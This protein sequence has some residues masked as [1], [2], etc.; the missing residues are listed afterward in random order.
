MKKI[1]VQLSLALS[2]SLFAQSYTISQ[3][4]LPK[5][6][7]FNLSPYECNEDCLE[8][9][10]QKGMV[11]SFLAN[12]NDTNV[13]REKLLEMKNIY[14]SIFNLGASTIAKQI[15]IAMLIPY[16]KIGKYAT[17]T[18]NAVFAYLMTKNYSFELKSFSIE[19]ESY[20]DIQQAFEEIEEEGFKYVIAPLTYQ[21]L[22]QLFALGVE[23]NIYIPTINK[24]DLEDIPENFYF[25]GI[26]Y[27][28]Q[29]KVLLQH[30]AS[31]LVIFYDTSYTGEKLR[32]IQKS[33]FLD[34]VEDNTDL[35]T[36]N[37]EQEDDKKVFIFPVSSHNSNLKNI[38]KDNDDL[39]NSS[40]VLDTP[41]V[42]SGLIMS[43]L[44]LY[45]VNTTNILS[46]QINYDPLL[47]SITQYEDR[48]QMIIA[49]SIT[50]KNDILIETNAL[51]KNDISYDW[52]NYTTTIG[53][54]YFFSMIAGTQRVY[55]IPLINNQVIYP[56]EL[57]VPSY[58]SFVPYSSS[59]V[60]ESSL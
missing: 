46:T 14:V 4:P 19:S 41:L 56:I 15:R 2:V 36:D 16:K 48:K 35:F 47:L 59:S 54:D 44:T 5:T 11:F 34:H 49:N 60:E 6:Y 50:E 30:A 42:K 57:K 13:S 10:L 31:P 52:I 20:E 39:N 12:I 18:T 23:Q 40:V 58:S 37:Y 51:L 38:L 3:I 17:T 27:K 29:S 53:I 9:Y 7:I 28:E 43:Q 21:G 8:E 33:I 45:D 26:D 1:F 55:K 32:D 22:E 25:G 24:E